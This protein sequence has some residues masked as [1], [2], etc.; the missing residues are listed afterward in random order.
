LSYSSS[1][2]SLFSERQWQTSGREQ[3]DLSP[4]KH[5]NDPNRERLCPWSQKARM[6]M[7]TA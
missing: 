5:S 3:A 4:H 7:K 1:T 2:R 6:G